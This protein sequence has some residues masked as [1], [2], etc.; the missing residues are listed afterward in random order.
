MSRTIQAQTYSTLKF[1][2]EPLPC[3]AL[4]YDLLGFASVVRNT[5]EALETKSL[6]DCL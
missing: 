3:F 2:V 6:D 5:T 1:Q 4:R